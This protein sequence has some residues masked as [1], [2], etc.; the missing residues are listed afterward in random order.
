MKLRTKKILYK[1]LAICWLNQKKYYVK[2]ST[3]ANYSV[4]L[5]NHLNL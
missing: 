5:F 3:Y 4:I 2:E 1:D